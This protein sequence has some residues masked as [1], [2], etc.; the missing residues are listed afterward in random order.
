LRESARSAS[1]AL[2]WR[3]TMVTAEAGAAKEGGKAEKA[4]ALGW[5]TAADDARRTRD[6]RQPARWPRARREPPG[7]V[8]DPGLSARRTPARAER[9]QGAQPRPPVRALVALDKHEPLVCVERDLQLAPIRRVVPPDHSLVE[10]PPGRDGLVIDRSTLLS[11]SATAPGSLSTPASPRS[12]PPPLRRRGPSVTR[13]G[14]SAATFRTPR[15]VLAP[16]LQQCGRPSFPR[17]SPRGSRGCWPRGG[18]LWRAH[19]ASMRSKPD[20]WGMSSP[21]A[22]GEDVRCKRPCPPPLGPTCLGI[23]PQI[24]YRSAEPAL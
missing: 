10:G 22:A 11:A 24:D 19:A 14:P 2:L 20:L 12:A 6:H 1:V 8:R 3:A 4:S 21:M 18:V 5:R 13:A 16:I 15:L 17:S 9:A 7:P 23:C